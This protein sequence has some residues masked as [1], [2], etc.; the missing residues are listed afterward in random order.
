[1][2][3]SEPWLGI[4]ADRVVAVV[5]S[6]RTGMAQVGSGYLLGPTTVITARHCIRDKRT[7]MPAAALQVIRLSDGAQAPA[8]F[9][10][11][12]LDVAV[13]AV[14]EASS[15]QGTAGL[16]PPPFGQVDA[17]HS[18]ELY[19]CQAVGF[20]LWQLEPRQQHRAAAEVHG[21]IRTTE[22]A[23]SGVLVLRDPL[24]WDVTVPEGVP[25]E[26]SALG[27]PWG[28][29]SG[30]L[31]FHDGMALG[32][33]VEHHPRQGRSALTILPIQRIAALAEQGDLDAAHVA[34]ALNIPRS[35]PLPSAQPAHAAGPAARRV[36]VGVQAEHRS[37]PEDAADQLSW[38]VVTALR[39]AGISP[40]R[41]ERQDH[42]ESGHIIILPAEITVRSTLSSMLLAVQL[43]VRQD[44]SA[45]ETGGRVRMLMSLAD[46]PVQLAAGRYV[47]P[48]VTAACG[49]LESPVLREALRGQEQPDLVAIIS[50]DLY[51]Q[52][53]SQEAGPWAAAQARA[54][55]MALPG[56][57]GVSR[58][59]LYLPHLPSA[60]NRVTAFAGFSRNSSITARSALSA[61][62]PLAGMGTLAWWEDGHG[63]H[64]PASAHPALTA[65][66]PGAEASGQ[67]A[68][69]AW[70][71]PQ[72]EPP[73]PQTETQ[74][75]W[76]AHL[77][78]ASQHH[79][80]G[81]NHL[82]GPAAD[83]GLPS[84]EEPQYQDPGADQPTSLS[85]LGD[86]SA[87]LDH[88][89]GDSGDW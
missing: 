2:G 45:A 60:A 8:K 4:P 54:I 84:W 63:H 13:L 73:G 79:D 78:T 46:G 74:D 66:R 55:D 21:V 38:I 47:G 41:C 35:G 17:T 3:G 82:S 51:S 75:P 30:A 7:G 25:R 80:H 56:T 42:G 53:G 14:P 18:G 26:D 62:I 87:P 65:H 89:V 12:A 16:C 70:P 48:G 36:T 68:P 11:A 43:A 32:V 37:R 83:P 81:T 85:D 86:F 69:A 6:L 20:P 58:C 52:F 77:P 72:H 24:L 44:N 71:S 33:I 19:D 5:A 88:G 27:S 76:S 57:P 1:M 59:W 29:L 10:S 40:D 23:E 22:G 67:H 9:S 39:A 31:V 61:A 64:D 15:W 49:M 34:W 50:E 28:G